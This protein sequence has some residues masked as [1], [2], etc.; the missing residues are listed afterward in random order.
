MI[1]ESEELT[2]RRAGEPAALGI[3]MAAG[4][5]AEKE[6]RDYLSRQSRIA[7]LQIENL[8]KVDKYQTS[9]LR[10]SRFNEQMKG[11]MQI[12]VVL[13]GA[14]IVIGVAA[15]LWN[16]S[17][18]NGLVVDSFAVPEAYAHAGVS[19]SVM[20][21]DMT[22]KIAAIR[23]FANDNSLA[24]SNEVRESRDDVGVEIP[25]TGIS[26]SEA[27]RYLRLWL[28]NEQHLNG[29]LRTLPDG[30]VSLT[31]SLGGSGTFV[32]TGKSNDLDALEQRT[33]E[34]VFAAVDPINYVLYLDAK[35]RGAE[36]LQAAAH[37]LT[38]WTDN[39]DLV[40]EYSLYAD[41]MHSITCNV[42]RALTLTNMGI[43]LDP[44]STPP[45]MES[46]DASRD[47]GHDEDVLAQARAI[48][49]LQQ[50]DNVVSWRTG[51]GYTW[52]QQLGAIS[53]AGETGDFAN[54]SVLPCR[55]YCSLASSA[56]LHGEA[57][58]RMRDVA[59]A[60]EELNRARTL[61]AMGA[62][63]V[64]V[65]PNDNLAITQYFTDTAREDWKAAV[66][67]AQHAAGGL[68]SDKSYSESLRTLRVQTQIIPL[69]AHALG[70]SGN[71]V[72]AQQA[73][74]ATPS[75]CYA[76]LRERGNIAAMN[77]NS[78]SAAYWFARAV[79][80]APSIPFAYADW[81]E[82]LLRNGHYDGAIAKFETAHAKGPHFADPLEMWGEALMQKSRSDLALAKF[83]AADKY[84]PNW[85]RL[86]LEWG[87]AL[88]YAGKH[89]EAKKQ[90]AIASTLDLS[91][92]DKEAI[93][94]WK[95]PHV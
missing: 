82:M 51:P 47:L 41:M 68:M 53:R 3:A 92:S 61:G 35:G 5:F 40:E 88:V 90:F 67:D 33:A 14:A 34:R 30:R 36:T 13:F 86:H 69:L 54:L 39:R 44:K 84:A 38:F 73:I 76:C 71:F 50:K 77:G 9:H 57:F 59:G 27:W 94:N 85:G 62:E 64:P 89:A 31:V 24:H 12:M 32:I 83:Q 91:P 79:R 60:I 22:E 7:D 10:S 23:D 72:A 37:D 1:D 19:G 58:A 21:D 11:A 29:N 63:D 66:I 78:G 56:L 45:H 28:G 46:L 43:A 25:E 42:R 49:A 74:A 8:Q 2:A 15:A 93:G 75:D 6:A 55:V 16:A 26:I 81:G 87:K 70:A 48:A 20:A 65:T 18:T 95:K 17:Q 4:S 52:V 80:A